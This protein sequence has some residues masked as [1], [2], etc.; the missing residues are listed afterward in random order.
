MTLVEFNAPED[1][2]IGLH[3]LLHVKTDLG[4]V[5]RAVRV[6]NLVKVLNA[7]DTGFLWNLL[8]GL[9]GRQGLLDVV[10]ACSSENDDV[11]K[12]IGSKSVRAVNRYASGFS[13]SVQTRNNFIL[14]LLQYPLVRSFEL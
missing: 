7:L 2:S 12:R 8:V 9:S 1:S 11:Q 3:S 5:E 4:S 6:S 10:G 14:T 13:S